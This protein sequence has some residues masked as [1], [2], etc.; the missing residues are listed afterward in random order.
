MRL[1]WW[2]CR[3]FQFQLR[4][5]SALT[6]EFIVNPAYI[7]C[8]KLPLIEKLTQDEEALADCLMA[9]IHLSAQENQ[10]SPRCLCS[11]KDLDALIKGRRDLSI[12][13][14]WRNELAGKQ[15][16]KFMSGDSQLSFSSG[17][18]ELVDV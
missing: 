3:D 5:E 12:L 17:K 16:L 1:V 13:N 14:G 2:R 4:A 7:A 11:R 18:L 9:V 8:P 15:L 10:I 6:S